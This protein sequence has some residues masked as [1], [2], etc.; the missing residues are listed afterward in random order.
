MKIFLVYLRAIPIVLSLLYESTIT[1]LFIRFKLFKILGIFFSSLKVFINNVR[2]FMYELLDILKK[3]DQYKS[4]IYH[5][6][7]YILNG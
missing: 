4:I 3:F 1:I 2:L 6:I 7:F 5:D